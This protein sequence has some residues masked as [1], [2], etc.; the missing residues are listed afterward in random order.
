AREH[1]HAFAESEDAP[2]EHQVRRRERRQPER[3]GRAQQSGEA[4]SDVQRAEAGDRVDQAEQVGEAPNSWTREARVEWAK[5]PPRVQQEIAKRETDMQRGVDQ[6]KQ[7]Y[8]EIDEALSPWH[9]EMQSFGK[10]P[11]QTIDQMFKWYA[12]MAQNPD[13]AFP[14]LLK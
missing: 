6:L 14:A 11:A 4:S 12:A 13:A 3:A 8:R 7:G 10:T 5:L 9:G 2:D 1:G